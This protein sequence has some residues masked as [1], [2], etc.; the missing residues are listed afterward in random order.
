MTIDPN[1]PAFRWSD[2]ARSIA[3]LACNAQMPEPERAAISAAINEAR[4]LGTTRADQGSTADIAAA[5]AL[6]AHLERRGNARV[7]QM[8]RAIGITAHA[9][10]TAALAAAARRNGV[11]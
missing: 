1:H 10:A 2:A 3:N 11:A 8:A 6:L 7:V 5:H 4:T 9:P